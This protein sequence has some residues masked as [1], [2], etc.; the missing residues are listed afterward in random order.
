[1]KLKLYFEKYAICRLGKNEKIPS[2]INTEKFYS[3]TKTQ[4]ELSIVCLDENIDEN[5]KCERDWRILKIQGPLD[6]SL[7]GILS[8]ISTLLAQNNISIFV[9]STY[10]TDYILVKEANI[11]KT[12]KLMIE[13]GYDIEKN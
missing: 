7:V 12:I 13:N 11:E 3:I 10:D 4:E 6:F 8:K 2:W 5:I 1:M 9:V